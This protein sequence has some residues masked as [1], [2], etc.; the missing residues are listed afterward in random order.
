MPQYSDPNI[1]ES[2][3]NIA[4]ILFGDPAA[5]EK[6]QYQQERAAV[7]A[8]QA[9]LLVEQARLSGAKANEQEAMNLAKAGWGD[10]LRG[11]NPALDPA[12]VNFL[13]TQIQAGFKPQQAAD[14]NLLATS[15]FP[16]V[17][18]NAL[19]IANAGAGNMPT[20]NTAITTGQQSSVIDQIQQAKA[21]YNTGSGGSKPKTFAVSGNTLQDI[22]YFA[23]KNIPGATTGENVTPGIFDNV[24]PEIINQA[25]N[26]AAKVYQSTGNIQDASQSFIGE[27]SKGYQFNQPSRSWIGDIGAPN[28]PAGFAALPQ[29]PAPQA[30]ATQGWSIKR[31]Q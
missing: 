2:A 26:N 31:I 3:T 21:K 17:S 20:A 11:T 9:K 19:R 15:L 22:P 13:A 16:N 28:T 25:T 7:S 24:P 29:Q 8:E 5:R 12:V 18:E 27:I 1:G 4:K 14:A 6:Q 30:P 23:L 10:A